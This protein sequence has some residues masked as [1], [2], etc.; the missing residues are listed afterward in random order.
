MPDEQQQG[1]SKMLL[2]VV[3]GLVV[4]AVLAWLGMRWYQDQQALKSINTQLTTLDTTPVEEI[5]P[6]SDILLLAAS[7]IGEATIVNVELEE[8]DGQ[9]VYKLK[10]SNGQVLV[11]NAVTGDKM[12]VEQSNDE[13]DDEL[14]KKAALTSG[15]TLLTFAEAR[16]I[17]A[18]VRAVAIRKIEL[19]NDGGLIIYKVEYIDEGKVELDARD[20]KVVYRKDPGQDEQKFGDDDF[21]DDKSKNDV[22]SDDD[23]D[24]VEDAKDSDDDE[25]H[26]DDQEDDDDDNDRIDDSEDEDHDEEDN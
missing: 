20:G 7:E 5:Q 6:V 15:Q 18:S 26:I 12:S 13:A 16:T 10:L 23:N 22:D 25:D 8:E 3:L 1:G 4:I 17:A 11:F 2:P 19:E 9:Q 14:L 24:K 21:D